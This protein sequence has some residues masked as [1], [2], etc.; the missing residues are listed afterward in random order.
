M[1][2]VH[3]TGNARMG[4]FA[5]TGPR[6][7]ARGAVTSARVQRNAT[8]ERSAGISPDQRMSG[9]A[10]SPSQRAV[11]PSALRVVWAGIA[12]R[13]SAPAGSV[14]P[15]VVMKMPAW[16]STPVIPEE[17]STQDSTGSA[18]PIAH[19]REEKAVGRVVFQ[20]EAV[21]A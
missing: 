8:G 2:R 7:E 13:R 18:H 12:F 17:I 16:G 5:R 20:A 21:S 1:H 19:S 11:E 9:I 3:P 10:E 6:L 14:R 15:C 4:N